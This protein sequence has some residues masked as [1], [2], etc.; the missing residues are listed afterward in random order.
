MKA[1]TMLFL[2]LVSST[3]WSETG[4]SGGG[5]ST[6]KALNA[7]TASS[8]EFGFDETDTLP[9]NGTIANFQNPMFAMN[10]ID[11]QLVF[12]PF[13][14][15]VV[16][17]EFNNDKILDVLQIQ[18]YLEE[19][20]GL[21]EF[22]S[23]PFNQ[24][25]SVRLHTGEILNIKK[26]SIDNIMI[27]E[28]MGNHFMDNRFSGNKLIINHFMDNQLAKEERPLDFLRWYQNEY[29]QKNN[30][31]FDFQNGSLEYGNYPNEDLQFN[32]NTHADIIEEDINPT[33][34]IINEKWQQQHKDMSVVFN[35]F[36]GHRYGDRIYFNPYKEEIAEIWLKDDTYIDMW[37]VKEYIEEN[38]QLP[39]MVDLLRDEVMSIIL[40]D[41]R[42][43]FIDDLNGL[44][45]LSIT[46]ESLSL[47]RFLLQQ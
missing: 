25:K 10:K 11:R 45:K 24:I 4:I 3:S 34:D 35:H 15:L 42:E 8:M 9:F 43:I 1:L 19:Y 39:S 22:I 47:E 7:M 44:N 41:G 32:D 29:F 36:W 30:T 27:N 2:F 16:D 28:F 17:I 6:G 40:K 31:S 26:F 20:E 13:D 18:N 46:P 38:Q 5:T 23:L 33:M 21:P 14:E 12:N 37:D